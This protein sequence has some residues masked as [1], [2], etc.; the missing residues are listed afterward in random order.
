MTGRE[1]PR[2]LGK[3]SWR[4]YTT[5]E[6]HVLKT[7]SVFIDVNGPDT[8]IICNVDID[9]QVHGHLGVDVAGC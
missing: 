8:A 4:H 3:G 9:L 5:A 7:L 1:L 6:G 2:H